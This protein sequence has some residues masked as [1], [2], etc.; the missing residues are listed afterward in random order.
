[1]SGGELLYAWH[2]TRT[3]DIPEILDFDQSSQEGIF[4]VAEKNNKC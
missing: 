3:D 4:R 1:M 2:E